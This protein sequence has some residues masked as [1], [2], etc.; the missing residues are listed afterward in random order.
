MKVGASDVGLTE[1]KIKELK[2]K[3]FDKL[4]EKHKPKWMSMA[5]D[6]YNFAKQHISVDHEPNPDDVAK[7]LLIMLEP[8]DVLTKH[9]ESNRC[10]YKSY[11]EKFCDYIVDAYLN[12]GKAA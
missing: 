7:A 10:K 3:D 2:A 4:L 12:G 8:D 11:R 5:E 1:L 6:A 9:Q